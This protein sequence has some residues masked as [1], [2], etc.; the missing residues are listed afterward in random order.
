[1][2][3]IT[4]T[5]SVELAFVYA[6]ASA[7]TPEERKQVFDFWLA[8]HDRNIASRVT[9]GQVYMGAL[10]LMKDD[11]EAENGTY[12]FE[13][14]VEMVKTVLNAVFGEDDS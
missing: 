3:Y 4:S 8:K 1:M 2:T 13:D 14:Y 6:D 12:G 10:A 9:E 11:P 5:K 7:A